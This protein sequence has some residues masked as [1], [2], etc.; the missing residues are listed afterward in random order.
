MT[1]M[2]NRKKKGSAQSH[3]ILILAGM[4][5]VFD[6]VTKYAAQVQL[7]EG[8]SVPLIPGLIHFTLVYNPGAAFGMFAGSRWFLVA[9]ALILTIILVFQRQRLFSQRRRVQW[10]AGLLLG[11]TVG[12]FIDRIVLGHVVDFLHVPGFSIFNGADTA[13]V[14]G[15]VILGWEVITHEQS[16]SGQP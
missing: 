1:A 13:I 12:N 6:Q 11:G 2:V 8:V 10:G 3:W 16:E 5:G 4:T 15:A 14:L 9:A 7:T